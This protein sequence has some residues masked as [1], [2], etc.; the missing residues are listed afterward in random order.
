MAGYKQIKPRWKKGESGNPAGKPKG[1]FSL[2]NLLK[3]KIQECPE[4]QDK[5]TYADLII[6]RMMKESIEKGD[7]QHIKTIWAY[8]E[9]MPKQKTDID[10]KSGGKVLQGFN[11]I[12][13]N[14]KNNPDNRTTTETAPSVADATGQN[15]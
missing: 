15:N 4:G 7:I 3:H 1:A 5:K 12:T 8:I 14:E 2:I 10:L 9:G 13:P 11:Y 6:Q